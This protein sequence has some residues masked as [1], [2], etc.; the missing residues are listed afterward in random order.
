M[1]LRDGFYTVCIDDFNVRAAD[2]EQ[3][4]S[5]TFPPITPAVPMSPSLGHSQRVGGQ[6]GTENSVIQIGVAFGLVETRGVHC[7]HVVQSESL[8]G[9]SATPGSNPNLLGG[10]REFT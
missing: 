9:I 8:G 1:L 5:G 4:C 3:S 10:P 2:L 6:V 7:W